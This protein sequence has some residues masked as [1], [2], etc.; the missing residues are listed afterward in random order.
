MAVGHKMAV[1]VLQL[2]IAGLGLSAH[3]RDQW[4]VRGN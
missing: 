2:T 4:E 3:A 1:P